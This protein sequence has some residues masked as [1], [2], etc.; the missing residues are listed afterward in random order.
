MRLN[1]FRG[2]IRQ[3][4]PRGAKAKKAQLPASMSLYVLGRALANLGRNELRRV[5]LV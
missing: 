3:G 1:C 5:S 4:A 2:Q